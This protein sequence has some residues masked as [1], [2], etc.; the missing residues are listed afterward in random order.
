MQ[1]R[2]HYKTI[3]PTS[4]LDL[5]P[6]LSRGSHFLRKSVIRRT[7]TLLHGQRI[8]QECAQRHRHFHCDDPFVAWRLPRYAPSAVFDSAESASTWKHQ[9]GF[10]LTSNA[11]HG[12]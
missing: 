10:I 9:G 6:L 11:V 12:V 7:G 1:D 3:T 8:A 5:N 2:F 4:G